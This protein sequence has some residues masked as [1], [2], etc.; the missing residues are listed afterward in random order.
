MTSG[1]ATASIARSTSRFRREPLRHALLHEIGPF[2]RRLDRG[3]EA[4][5]AARRQR[6]ADEPGKGAL[7]VRDHLAD[8]AFRLGAGIVNGDVDPREQQARDPAR[9]DHPAADA[10]GFPG[11]VHQRRSSLSFARTSAGPSTRAPMPCATATARSTSASFVA[12]TPF[13]SQRLSSS[14][15]RMLPPAS[16]ASPA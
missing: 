14:P 5:P 7:G 2:D 13:S 9:A 1:P 3:G 10:G 11:R 4:E 8:D 16:I 12:S 15:T 6:R